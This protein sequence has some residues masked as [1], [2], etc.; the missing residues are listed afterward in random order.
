MKAI[1]TLNNTPEP[2]ILKARDITVHTEQGLFYLIDACTKSPMYF[3]Q[4]CD[5]K[6]VVI[7]GNPKPPKQPHTRTE[8]LK[9]NITT[10]A[11][12]EVLK[13][14]MEELENPDGQFMTA[15]SIKVEQLAQAQFDKLIKPQLDSFRMQLK[16]AGDEITQSA[17]VYN[18]LQQDMQRLQRFVEDRQSLGDQIGELAKAL[19][20]PVITSSIQSPVLIPPVETPAP[21][22]TQPTLAEPDWI[23]RPAP[24]A[25]PAENPTVAKEATVELYSGKRLTDDRVMTSER[26]GGSSKRPCAT[27]DGMVYHYEGCSALSQVHDADCAPAE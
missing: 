4:Q 15:L 8:E 5:I 25:M 11:V 10:D 21:A 1:L 3:C 17:K 20:P 19:M 18:E 14:L 22:A 9:I 7:T 12:Q 26:R 24:A 16:N 27:C 2:V 6:S 13:A 23:D